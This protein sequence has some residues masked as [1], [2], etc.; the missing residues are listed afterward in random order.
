M[1]SPSAPAPLLTLR[2][3]GEGSAK[4]PRAERGQS[5]V[6]FA[7]MITLLVWLLAGILDLGRAYFTFL[8]LRDAAGEGA[9]YGSIHPTWHTSAN[10]GDPNNIEYRVKNSAPSGG[11]V[12]WSTTTVAVNAPDTSPGNPIQVT[13][14]YSY[15]LLTPFIGAIVGSQTLPLGASAEAEILSPG[16]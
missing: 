6:E 14:T 15:T 1:R 3:R 7:L 13:A 8:A 11:L 5:L 10:S 12:D 4:R 2:V 16:P 9:Y